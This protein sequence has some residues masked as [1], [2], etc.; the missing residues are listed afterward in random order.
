MDQLLGFAQ[1]RSALLKFAQLC[2]FEEGEID[3]SRA[4]TYY[5]QDTDSLLEL[6]KHVINCA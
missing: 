4:Q 1:L 2:T 3:T 5:Q 6:S